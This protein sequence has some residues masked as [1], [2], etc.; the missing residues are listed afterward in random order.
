MKKIQKK[1]KQG[2]PGEPDN[3]NKNP[4]A[5]LLH[6][7]GVRMLFCYVSTSPFNFLFD[8]TNIARIN[9][10][11]FENLYLRYVPILTEVGDDRSIDSLEWLSISIFLDQ[12][13]QRN[14]TLDFEFFLHEENPVEAL[15]EMPEDLKVQ[16]NQIK[17]Y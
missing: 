16:K 10:E 13:G 4:K 15:P 1:K 5:S 6:F 7:I 17:N 2:P 11:A 12:D 14:P 3:S 8:N 9:Y